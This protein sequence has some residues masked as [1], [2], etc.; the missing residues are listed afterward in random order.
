MTNRIARLLLLWT[1]T[2]A[3]LPAQGDSL[4]EANRLLRVSGT[5]EQFDAVTARQAN[6]IIRHYSIIVRRNTDVSLPLRLRR[7]IASCYQEVYAW[8]NFAPGIATL[9]ARTLD[10]HQLRLL[11]DFYQSRGLPPWEID[12]FKQIIGL[13]EEFQRASADFIYRNS[14]SCVERDAQLIQ[15]FLRDHPDLSPLSAQAGLHGE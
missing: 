10:E 13:A 12:T 15:A 5:G 14:A 4:R 2:L 11:I 9:L 1:L 7:A 6:N 8:D 3:S